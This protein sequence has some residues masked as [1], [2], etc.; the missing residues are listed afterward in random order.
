MK[1]VRRA[2][3]I[4]VALVVFISSA[5][6]HSGKTDSSGGHNDRIH[7]GYHY[8]HGYPAHQHTNGVCPYNFD[9]KTGYSSGSSSLSSSSGGRSDA[10]V[11]LIAAVVLF[12]IYGLPYIFISIRERRSRKK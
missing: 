4:L 12:V 9:D 11:F 5:S 6:A 10:S 8:H 3:V 1:A 7:G 2:L